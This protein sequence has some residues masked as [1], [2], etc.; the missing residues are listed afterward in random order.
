VK[1]TIFR[2]GVALICL[3]GIV[4]AGSLAPAIEIETSISDLVVQESDGPATEELLV[5]SDSSSSPD[6]SSASGSNNP[7]AGSNGN[8]GSTEGSGGEPSSESGT[9]AD[10]TGEGSESEGGDSTE[11]PEDGSVSEL[12][13]E[14][15][16]GVSG[17]GYPEQRTVGG[18]LS[19]SDQIF[20]KTF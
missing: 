7:G 9:G 3:L 19:L 16:G 14:S 11:L 8:G 5:D 18:S 13:I 12:G 10:S 1:G 17:D 6:G 4:L 15:Y 2:F 20:Q